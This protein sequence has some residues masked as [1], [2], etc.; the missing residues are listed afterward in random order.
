M[1]E[2]ARRGGAGGRWATALAQVALVAFLAWWVWR[3]LVPQFA[4]LGAAD[5]TR[6]RPDPLLLAVS[7]LLLLAVYLGHALLWRRILDHLGLGRPSLRTTLRVYFLAGLGRYVPG[8]LWQFAGLAILSGR[9][10]LPPGGAAAAQVLGQLAFLTTG[11]LLLALLLPDLWSGPWALLAAA[12]LVAASVAAWLVAT[13]APG[14]AAREWLAARAGARLGGKVRG[15]FA[16]ADRVSTGRALA[17]ASGYGASWLVL[18][19]AFTLFVAAFVP[20]AEVLWRSLTGAVA[21]AYLF[22]YAVVL[23]PAGLGARELSMVP[24]L[25]AAFAGW[26][27]SPSGVLGAVL[28]VTVASRLWFTAAELLPLLLL[29]LVPSSDGADPPPRG[30]GS[31]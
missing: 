17:W 30:S 21:G 1:A 23:A 27:G 3:A 16:L 31:P 18:G 5:L 8:K 12:A 7:M 10:G 25:E 14:H 2:A 29:L 13:T 28:V 4:A 22:G 6:W 19:A 9:A 24:L 15:A 26:S 20:G 11:L